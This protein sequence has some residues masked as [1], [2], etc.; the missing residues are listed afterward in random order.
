MLAAMTVSS[1]PG[2]SVIIPITGFIKLIKCEILH[3]TLLG[4]IC[5]NESNKQYDVNFN[6]KQ[7]LIDQYFSMINRLSNR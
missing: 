7:F 4:T 1:L 2:L 3:I 5:R 6:Q